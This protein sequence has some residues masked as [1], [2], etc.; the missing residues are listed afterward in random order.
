MVQDEP[1]PGFLL[2]ITAKVGGEERLFTYDG[3]VVERDEH[4]R[5]FEM[6]IYVETPL[7]GG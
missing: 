7:E 6:L 3:T 4:G 1:G 2:A 5:P